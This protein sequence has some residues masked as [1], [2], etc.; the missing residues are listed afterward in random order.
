MYSTRGSDDER[1][2][3]LF[4][5]YREACPEPE[6]SAN[7][8]PELWQKIEA[9]QTITFSFG[10]MASAFVTA[11]LA[12]SLGLGIYLTRPVANTSYFSQSYV[13]ALSASDETTDILEPVRYEVR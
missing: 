3:N 7:F 12:F 11:A 6:A 4:R 2:D 5:A 13:E 10:R 8:M 1:L 9:R